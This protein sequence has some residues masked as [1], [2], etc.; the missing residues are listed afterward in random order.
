MSQNGQSHFKNLASNAAFISFL[1]YNSLAL[2]F[3]L[4]V[5]MLVFLMNL[6]FVDSLHCLLDLYDSLICHGVLVFYK[7][8]L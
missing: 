4:F 6:W 5:I 3:S 8:Y 7:D 2:L 1:T